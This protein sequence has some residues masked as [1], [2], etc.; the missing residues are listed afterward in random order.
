SRPYKFPSRCPCS[1]HTPVMRDTTATGE[2]GAVT[3]CTGEFACPSQKVEH[4]KHFVSRRAFHIEGLAEKPIMLFFEQSC[5]QGPADIF[6]R[7][8]RNSKSQ[9]E[10]EEGFGALSVRTLFHAVAARR[11]IALA[12][13]IY[14]LG[15]AHVGETRSR[16]LG[17]GC[18]SW[19]TFHDDSLSIARGD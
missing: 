7:E 18:G 17:R 9:L 14:S 11:E 13:F 2:E 15:T 4:L 16:A 5:L 6:T 3:R 19:Q 12:R 8:A 10:E 1:L